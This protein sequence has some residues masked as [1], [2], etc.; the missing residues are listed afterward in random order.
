MKKRAIILTLC[1]SSCLFAVTLGAPQ[2]ISFSTYAINDYS[3]FESTLGSLK[4]SIAHKNRFV[5]K[6]TDEIIDKYPSTSISKNHNRENSAAT[7]SRFLSDNTDQSDFVF[8]AGHGNQQ[9][10]AFY[11]YA[12]SFANGNKKFGGNTKWVIIDACLF[13]NANKTNQLSSD[14]SNNS[15]VIDNARL[16]NIKKMFNGVHAILSY[17]SKTSGGNIKKHWYSSA[18]WRTE[19]KYNHFAKYFIRDGRGLW[20]AYSAAIYKHYDDFVNNHA[21]GW[22]TDITGY[23][24]AIAYFYGDFNNGNVIDMSLETYNSTY[25]APIT[26]SSYNFKFVD[27]KM[28][29]SKAGTPKY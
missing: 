26:T 2:S 16:T 18:Q 25:N 6:M 27:I 20:D 10:L 7:A 23:R 22:T 8:F 5:E 19:D 1:L 14:P 17:H 9:I 3:H 12:L 24:S 21:V 4:R 11:D 15:S 13:L 29:Y 28:A